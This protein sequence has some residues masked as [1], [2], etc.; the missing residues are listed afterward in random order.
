MFWS[1]ELLGRWTATSDWN[2]PP[3]FD[4]AVEL[5]VNR[6]ALCTGVPS[7]SASPVMRV[8]SPS[9]AGTRSAYGMHCDSIFGPGHCAMSVKLQLRCSIFRIRRRVSRD[10]I[11]C[12]F[13]MPFILCSA[14]PTATASCGQPK[15]PM[16]WGRVTNLTFKVD[17]RRADEV[18]V[19]VRLL[20]R[21]CRFTT[22]HVYLVAC[23]CL[24]RDQDIYPLNFM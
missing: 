14:R 8:P 7:A 5:Q 21:R 15:A 17:G 23:N 6:R 3:P 10:Y 18:A 4:F 19:I 13:L 12:D 1:E 9:L 24:I 16:T 22:H 20:H 11:S 2:W